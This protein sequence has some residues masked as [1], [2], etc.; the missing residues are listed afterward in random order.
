VSD[1]AR[2]AAG[3]EDRARLRVAGP[4]IGAPTC[5]PV[6]AHP[7]QPPK[8]ATPP[9]HAT[10]SYRVW[11]WLIIAAAIVTGWV[12]PYHIAFLSP[13]TFG[14]GFVGALQAIL[15]TLFLGDI[16]LSFF[17]G[18]YDRG[19]LV[20]DRRAIVRS[21][22][23]FRLWWDLLTTLPWDAIVLAGAGLAGSQGPAAR[24]ISLLGLLKLVRVGRG[25]GWGCVVGPGGVFSA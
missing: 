25:G 13:S 22:A 15:L 1:V 10:R 18:Y 5:H 24:Y 19:L 23:S 12:E 3:R 9:T 4:A 6:A 8:P 20:V 17:V 11:W 16:I 14:G 2:P 21:Y 7:N